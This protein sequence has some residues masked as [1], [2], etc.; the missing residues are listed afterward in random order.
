MLLTEQVVTNWPVA[1]NSA[2]GKTLR[3]VTES[4]ENIPDGWRERETYK[5]VNQD[6]FTEVFELGPT[7]EGLSDLFREPV[8][9]RE[10]TTCLPRR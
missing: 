7:A 5:V 1:T 9:A 8:E 10:V 2:D 3:F 6:E 4:I